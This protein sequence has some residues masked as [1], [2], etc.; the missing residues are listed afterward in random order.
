[1]NEQQQFTGREMGLL[2]C[3]S[4]KKFHILHLE[5]KLNEQYKFMLSLISE[6]KIAEEDAWR[7]VKKTKLTTQVDSSLFGEYTEIKDYERKDGKIVKAHY[8]DGVFRGTIHAL[9]NKPVGV[10]K[11]YV[12]TRE[13][14]NIQRGGELVSEIFIVKRRRV[15]LCGDCNDP[16]CDGLDCDIPEGNV[17]SMVFQRPSAKPLEPGSVDDD[18]DVPLAQLRRR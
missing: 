2:K 13:R 3:A 10:M 16:E 17:R 5:E 15:L 8:I 9:G 18:D 14:F 6:G 7:W 12:I 4:A 11:K 1:M